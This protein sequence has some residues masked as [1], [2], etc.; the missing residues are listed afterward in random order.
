ML[1]VQPYLFS[2]GNVGDIDD[3]IGGVDVSFRRDAFH[4]SEA[5]PPLA[6]PV[7]PEA[8]S[9]DAETVKFNTCLK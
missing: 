2:H 4:N 9:S 7:M 1:V 8:S 3:P 5:D 6:G